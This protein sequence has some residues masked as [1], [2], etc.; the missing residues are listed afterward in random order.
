MYGANMKCEIIAL[1]TPLDGTDSR[2]SE[3]K[4]YFREMLNYQDFCSISSTLKEL[5]CISE[6]P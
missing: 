1:V 6:A 5:Y 2:A 3:I 4:G